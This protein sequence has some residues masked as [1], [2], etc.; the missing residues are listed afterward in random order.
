[1]SEKITEQLGKKQGRDS[2]IVYRATG[3]NPET[4]ELTIHVDEI[5]DPR[6]QRYL[7]EG[8]TYT[9]E[10][11]PDSDK[12]PQF[13]SSDP[14]ELWELPTKQKKW[15]NESHVAI[16]EYNMVLPQILLYFWHN[17]SRL[18]MEWSW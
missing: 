7:D 18:S 9:F 1:M 10:I 16:P 17:D 6:W 5:G 11:H 8:V 12:G 14:L 4:K 13:E 3:Y 15:V 2:S